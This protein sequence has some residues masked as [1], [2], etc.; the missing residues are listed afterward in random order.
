M[1]QNLSHEG[2]SAGQTSAGIVPAEVENETAFAECILRTTHFGIAFGPRVVLA[3]IDLEVRG[4]G[5]TALLGPGG[6]G[7]ST[8]LHRLARLPAS[9]RMRQWGEIHYL[10]L[11]LDQ[12]RVGPALVHQ[13]ARDLSV[14][15][16]EGLI[17][18]LR[19]AYPEAAMADLRRMAEESLDTHDL[20]DLRPRLDS[21]VA[22]LPAAAIRLV[23][24]LR[25]S[26]TG[27][28]LLLM[29]EPT[30]GLGEDDARRVLRLI[31]LLGQRHT[32]LMTTHNQRHAREIAD[33]AVLMAG[34]RIQVATT[35][36]AFFAN[37]P[38]HPVLAQFLRTGSCAVPAPDAKQHELADGTCLPPPLPQVAMAVATLTE[39]TH[40]PRPVGATNVDP[41]PSRMSAPL[42]TRTPSSGTE[43]I[44]PCHSS[45]A[46][47]ADAPEDS[48]G[49]QG[50][51][52]LIPGR[53]AG[54]PMPG[55]VIP[56]HHDLAL[57]RRMG[58]T[59][60]INL[61]EREIPESTLAEF[62]I[63]SYSLQIKDRHAPPLLWAK[64]LLAKMETFMRDGEVLA[65]HCLAG[66]G[67][68][69]TVL[70]AWLIREGLTA[71]EALRRLRRIDPGF[72]Q[73]QVQE[74]LLHELETNLLIRAK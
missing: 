22:E 70:C 17:A 8:L 19:T 25:A 12:V 57:L 65:V 51:H 53:L 1:T 37:T 62:G 35:A 13:Q 24:L 29:D 10:G 46:P 56:L 26:L 9:G 16:V 58:I 44:L 5:I 71:D 41:P 52:W 74:D 20:G 72:V 3:D 39:S 14:K 45:I 21:C 63:R 60:L 67:R 2:R 68:T 23:S 31:Q 64:L 38:R 30:H 73:S 43:T 66:L 54:C 69:G 61:T 28:A 50:F 7:K 32:C 27:A 36:T 4:P 48:R 18:S 47:C 34:G 42:D 15:L 40:S 59:L 6:T 55:V 33:W 11:P 49:P